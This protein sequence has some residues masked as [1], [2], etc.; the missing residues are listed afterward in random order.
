M[1]TMSR[2]IR[3]GSAERETRGDTPGPKPELNPEFTY[4][5]TGVRVD[6]IRLGGAAAQTRADSPEGHI[7][8]IPV[9]RWV[10]AGIHRR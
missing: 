2:L 1:K 9:E 5:D 4:N 7:E 8:L 6:V 3:L 10:M